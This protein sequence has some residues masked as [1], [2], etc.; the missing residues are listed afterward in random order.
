MN[1]KLGE[2][3]NAK[4]TRNIPLTTRIGNRAVF[5]PAG[6]VVNVARREDGVILIQT[7]TRTYRMEERFLAF[8]KE[9]EE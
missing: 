9:V 3:K 7:P 2:N 6:A 5:I 4:A 8:L 1:L